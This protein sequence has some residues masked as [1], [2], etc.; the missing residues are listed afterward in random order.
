MAVLEIFDVVLKMTMTCERCFKFKIEF[1][2]NIRE[3][4]KERRRDCII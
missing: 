3:K 1:V 2:E 4:L